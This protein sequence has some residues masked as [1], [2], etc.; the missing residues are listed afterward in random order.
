[1]EN[2]LFLALTAYVCVMSI[3]PGPNNVML[4]SSGLMFGFRRTCPHML[5]IPLGVILQLWLTGAGLGALLALE[6]RLQ[7]AMKVAGS[8]YLLWLAARLWQAAE[9]KETRA[10]RPITF[11]QAMAFQFVNPKA[12]L[13]AATAVAVCAPPGDR[14]LGHLAV[15]CA[16]FAAVG[17]PC[18]AVWAGFGAALRPW[19]RRPGTALWINRAMAALTALTIVL[20]WI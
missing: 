10:R 7:M 17:L 20:F 3:T 11:L 8:L 13:T 15:S 9:L 2:S 1:M 18:I 16:V 5:G 14:Y 4:M 6:P 12:W 19:L